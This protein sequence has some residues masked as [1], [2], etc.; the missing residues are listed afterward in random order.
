MP[1]TQAQ[2]D[3]FEATLIDRNGVVTATFADQ[4]VT[5]ASYEDAREYLAYL[6]RQLAGGPITRVVATSKDL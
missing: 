4:S 5:F 6:K 2:I 3:Q 1:V